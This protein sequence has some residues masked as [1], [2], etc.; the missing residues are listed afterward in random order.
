MERQA[1]GG[2]RLY[3]HRDRRAPSCKWA[4]A[5]S[6]GARGRA[7]PAVVNAAKG[8]HAYSPDHS[9]LRTDFAP[10][11]RMY[12]YPKQAATSAPSP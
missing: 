2:D 9:T 4:Q 11:I 8:V 5:Q 12:M 6:A 1:M 3:Q 10:P 7:F